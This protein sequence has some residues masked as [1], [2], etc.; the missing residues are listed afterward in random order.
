M[1]NRKSVAIAVSACVFAAAWSCTAFAGNPWDERTAAI[2]EAGPEVSGHLDKSAL[3][4]LRTIGEDLFVSRFTSLDGMGRPLA[5]QAIVPTLRK[6]P[7]PA[8]EFSRTAGMDANS[9][10][11]CH[12]APFA[13][14]AGDFTTNVFVS[15]GFESADFDSTDPQFSNERGTNSIFGD[16]LLEL[17]AREMTAELQAERRAALRQAAKEGKEVR[18]ALTAKGV[19]FGHLT[20]SPDGMVAMNELDGV[21]MDLV[22]RP[23]TQKGVMTSLRQFTVNAMNQHEGMEATERFGARFTGTDD[24]DGD[25]VKNE[26][27]DGDISAL[28]AWQ[29]TLPP[30][31]QK[32]PDDKRWQE[33]S[34]SG[35][36]AF[37]RFGCTACHKPYLPLSS[38]EFAD[39]GPDDVA[40]TLN[41]SQVKEPAI[42]DLALMDWAKKR[43]K[44]ND[45]G[46]Y[47]IPLFGDLK[48]H[49]MTDS[50]IEVFGNEL[51]PQR[52]V[53]RNIFMT[54]ELWGVAST[55]PYG[56]RNDI[57]TLNEVILAHAGDARA[58]RDAYAD[59]SDEDRSN[60]IAF[61]KTLVIEQ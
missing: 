12:N 42:Y 13:G 34:A 11:S 52:F 59:A 61:L 44:R 31:V 16:G 60:L 9:C 56:H 32:V 26:L 1:T 15:E 38:L 14:G 33:A 10:A 3:E 49:M 50:S 25:K 18:V 24:F 23:F 29:A 39:P 7:S 48:R 4:K 22:I 40:G 47:L 37:D 36:K 20:A 53:D 54:A 6:H 46:E 17:L 58:S 8:G 30:P 19:S 51:L 5:T 55:A 21:D 2:G 45:K 27:S 35:E 28:V 43:L 57:T 41:T